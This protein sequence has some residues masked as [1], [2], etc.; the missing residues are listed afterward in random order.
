[1]RCT[2]EL[3]IMTENLKY[4]GYLIVGRKRVQ[5]LVPG[6]QDK[7]KKEQRKIGES[8]KEV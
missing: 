1:M 7:K 2:K 8:E 5:P 3:I 6:R 4:T